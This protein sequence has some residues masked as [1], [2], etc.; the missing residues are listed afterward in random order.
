MPKGT[1]DRSIYM[2]QS[3]GSVAAAR[4]LEITTGKG[5][6]KAASKA[7]TTYVKQA[8]YLESKSFLAAQVIRAVAQHSAQTSGLPL[9]TTGLPRGEDRPHHEAP[10]MG[11]STPPPSA[12]PSHDSSCETPQTTE[13]KP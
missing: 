13:N 5:A 4:S 2:M 11:T 8:L 12:R 7:A 1:M 6:G 3:L 10:T 9:G